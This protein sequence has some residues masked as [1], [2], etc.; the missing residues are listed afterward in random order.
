MKEE[1]QALAA[2]IDQ[3]LPYSL[4]SLKQALSEMQL[5]HDKVKADV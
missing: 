4:I 1:I 3:G 5:E 2:E